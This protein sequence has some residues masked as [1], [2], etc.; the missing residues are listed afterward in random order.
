LIA[1]FRTITLVRYIVITSKVERGILMSFRQMS[2]RLGGILALA[3]A[4]L[5]A[6]DGKVPTSYSPVVI[7][8]PFPSVMKRMSAAKAGVMQKQTAHLQAR[9]D[10]SDRP[11]QRRK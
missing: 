10:L 6:Q 1:H 11:R 7:Q 5:S 3:G 9:Y 4:G 2:I 8:E